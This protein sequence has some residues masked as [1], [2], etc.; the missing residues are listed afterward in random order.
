MSRSR[1]S[2]KGPGYEYW[3]KRPGNKG[4]GIPGKETKKR[5]HK[6]ERSQAKKEIIEKT[7]K[8][9][10]CCGGPGFVG[11]CDLCGTYEDPS[12]EFDWD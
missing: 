2:Q 3:G 4:G 11:Y 10:Y 1:K 9:C 6:A 5:T 12:L 8:T 7:E